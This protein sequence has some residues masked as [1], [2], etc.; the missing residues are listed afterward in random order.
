[1]KGYF[2]VAVYQ[3]R[4]EENVG[5]LWRTANAYGAAFMATV[6]RR[7]GRSQAS[8]TPRSHCHVPL[9]HFTDITDLLDHLPR[10]CPL[11]GVEL[12]PRA[13]L[14]DRFTHPERGL[15]LLGAE[16][17]G[18]PPDVIDS[19]HHLVQVPSVAMWSLNVAVAGG[20][21]VAHRHM[22]GTFR[23]ILESA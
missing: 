10:G 7:Y 1:M 23:S 18:L 13:V 8:D 4:H 11:V 12:D 16:D 9:F 21:V 22:S 19:C 15:Y 17:H 14:L 2:G 3:P 5:S 6:G 20:I